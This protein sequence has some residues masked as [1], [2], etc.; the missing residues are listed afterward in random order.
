MESVNPGFSAQSVW[1][2]TGCS[3]GFGRELARQLL[4]QGCPTVVTARNPDDLAE[5]SGQTHA[6]S[7]SLT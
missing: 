6:F 1:F 2:V 7:S 5:F 3:T 4:A